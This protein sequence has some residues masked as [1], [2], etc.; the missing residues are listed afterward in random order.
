MGDRAMIY[1]ERYRDQIFWENPYDLDYASFKSKLLDLAMNKTQFITPPAGKDAKT[2]GIGFLIAVVVAALAGVITHFATGAG[3]G[4][5]V[6]AVIAFFM[7]GTVTA[8]IVARNRLIV[9]PSKMTQEVNAK[10][11]GYSLTGSDG[12]M[13]RCPVFKYTYGG[14]EYLA[15]EG[16]YS[17]RGERPE[18]DSMVTIRV[19]HDDPAEFVWND[20]NNQKTFVFSAV[21]CV[22]MFL[23]EIAMLIITL[24]DKG[25][26]GS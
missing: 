4:A 7:V 11:V 13:N 23:V 17:N 1:D 20:R 16:N 3:I 25:L 9:R 19:D 15:Y 22:I 6:V 8:V 2:V 21:I 12:H 24:S 26:M 5:V 10:C 18:I 14:R